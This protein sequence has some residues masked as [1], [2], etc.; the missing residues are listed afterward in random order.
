M[1]FSS[2]GTALTSLQLAKEA[3]N[4]ILG[5]RDFNALAPKI[6]AINDQLLKA[7]DGLSMYAAKVADLQEKLLAATAELAQLK[8]KADERER[9]TL[10]ELS[11]GIFVYRLKDGDDRHNVPV[12][13]NA[14][15]FHYLCQKCF[16]EGTKS[17]LQQSAGVTKITLDCFNCG[18]KYFTGH[19]RALDPLVF[20]SEFRT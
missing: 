17:I 9:Y 11:S 4:S 3:L 1:D 12:E 5:I 7:Q 15:P 14:E 16:H 18:A 2:V 19:S 13:G 10:V 6:A 20:S 8:E